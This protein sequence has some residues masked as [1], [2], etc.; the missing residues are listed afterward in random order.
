MWA[1]FWELWQF[2]GN[3]PVMVVISG[4]GKSAP[5]TDNSFACAAEMQF[6]ALVLLFPDPKHNNRIDYRGN[7]GNYRVIGNQGK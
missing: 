2:S 3:F 7:R 1:R 4:A 6:V 5:R